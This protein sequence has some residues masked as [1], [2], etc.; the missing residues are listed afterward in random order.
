M[1]DKFWHGRL[2]RPFKLQYRRYGTGSQVVVLLHGLVSDSSFW[3]PLAGLLAAGNYTVIVPDLLGHGDSPK[4][5]YMSYSTADQAVSVLA[6]LRRLG[7]GSYILVGHSM[8]CLVASRMATIDTKRVERLLLY[9]PPLY[10]DAPEFKSHQRRRKFYFDIYERIATNP[11]G[12]LTMTRLVAKMS[13]NW[14]AFLQS[15]QTWLPIERSLRNAII[16][17]TS[18]EELSDIAIQTDIIHGRL[19]I[20]VSRTDLKRMLKPNQN[21]TFHRT[22]DRH[23]L[24]KRSAQYLARLIAPELEVSDNKKSKRKGTHASITE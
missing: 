16:A 8:G 18:F 2:R 12:R 15:E 14:T 23:G 7:V 13:R 10:T 11:S 19:D 5:Q 24:S 1:I 17:Q 21:I 3:E 22:T 20:A 9:E 6:L 4:P